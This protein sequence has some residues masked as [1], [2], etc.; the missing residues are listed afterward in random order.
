MRERHNA[1]HPAQASGDSYFAH[2]D[3]AGMQTGEI[4]LLDHAIRLYML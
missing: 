2:F 4:S 3:S 1:M